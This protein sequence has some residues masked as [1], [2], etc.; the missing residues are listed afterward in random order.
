M[1]IHLSTTRIKKLIDTTFV[2]YEHH[3]IKPVGFWY[4]FNNEWNDF[5][6]NNMNKKYKYKYKY[7]LLN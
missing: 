3:A 1:K 4:S 6:K 2:V 5:V 7:R